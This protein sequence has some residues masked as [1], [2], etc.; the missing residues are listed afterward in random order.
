MTSFEKGSTHED[1]GSLI[2]ELKLEALSKGG[3]PQLFVDDTGKKIYLAKTP[4][5]V[6]SLAPS[7]TEILF[8][9]GAG[10]LVV[11]VTELCD[12]PPEALTKEA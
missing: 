7:I 9:I 3:P 12:Y 2:W 10:N 6:I 8:A 1:V 4:N 11:G 5:R